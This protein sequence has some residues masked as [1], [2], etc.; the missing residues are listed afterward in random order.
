MPALR[1]LLRH[2]FGS[3]DILYE[4]RNC[5]TTLEEDTEQCPECGATDIATY[6]LTP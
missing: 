3:E 5:G 6:Q 2:V 1:A 4:C